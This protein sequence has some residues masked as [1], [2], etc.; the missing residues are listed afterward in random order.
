MESNSRVIDLSRGLG[1]RLWLGE[2]PDAC[3]L[4]GSTT[5]RSI[6]GDNSV[7]AAASKA[8]IELYRMGPKPIYALLGADAKPIQENNTS[9]SIFTTDP[10][11]GKLF[12][13][14]RAVKVDTLRVGLPDEY[15]GGVNNGIDKFTSKNLFPCLSVKLL[16]AVHGLVGS[17]SLAFEQITER[18]LRVLA[19]SRIQYSD[20]D[21]YK[22]LR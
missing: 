3:F 20:E 22:L 4:P 18:L 14:S 17:S 7:E 11:A 5:L 19:S 21:F 15:L 2:L 13:H 9:I 16:C 8:A 1:L 12:T 6:R 10:D